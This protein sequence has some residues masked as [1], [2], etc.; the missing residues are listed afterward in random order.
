MKGKILIVDDQADY[1]GL[2]RL[3]LEHDYQITE[4]ES[5]VALQ[6]AFTQDPPDV[7]LLDVKLPD[8]NGVLDLL[9]LIKKR[10]P[11]TAV[12]LFKGPPNEREALPLAHEASQG[13]ASHFLCK[14]EKLHSEKILADGRNPDPH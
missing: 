11:D 3:H 10:W 2:L 8:A 12:M 5:G 1:R 6:K 9:P 4:A 7:V 14:N 13:G